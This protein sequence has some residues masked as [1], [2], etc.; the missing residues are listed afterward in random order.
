MLQEDVLN[1]LVGINA[2]TNF[3]KTKMHILFNWQMIKEEIENLDLLNSVFDLCQGIVEPDKILNI[4]ENIIISQNLFDGKD[5]SKLISSWR[6]SNELQVIKALINALNGD[7][8]SIGYIADHL[9]FENSSSLWSL[10]CMIASKRSLSITELF[11]GDKNLS[12]KLQRD[13]RRLLEKL[14]TTCIGDCKILTHL[15]NFDIDK[16][17]MMLLLESPANLKL[18]YDSKYLDFMKSEVF[19]FF[20]TLW[21]ENYAPDLTMILDVIAPFINEKYGQGNKLQKSESGYLLEI[22]NIKFSTNSLASK[23]GENINLLIEGMNHSVLN[24]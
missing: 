3:N 21:S 1:I 4:V 17:I 18:I 5:I 19:D 11:K 24:T 16:I 7:L 12:L 10:L 15:Y 6:N 22:S 23:A 14:F 2:F 20:E 9:F 8:N 13:F